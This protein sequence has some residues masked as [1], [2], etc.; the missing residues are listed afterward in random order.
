MEVANGD[1]LREITALQDNSVI[2][3][4]MKEGKLYRKLP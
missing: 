1:P 2:K 3:L 4:M